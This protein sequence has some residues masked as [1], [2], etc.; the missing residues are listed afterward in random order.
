MKKTLLSLA[1]A[2]TLG[3]VSASA[4]AVGIFNEFTVAEGSVPGATANTF[5]ADKIN[6]GYAETLTVNGDGTFDTVGY[7]DWGSFFKNDGA[8]LVSPTQ[9]NGLN[10][11]AMYAVF[12]SSGNLTPTGF[13][14]LTGSF[15]LYID[16]NQNTSKT[17][18]GT[19]TGAVG[20]AGTADDYKIAF[21]TNLIHGKG[22][23]GTPGAFDL[24]FDDFTLTTG[25][26]NGATAGTQ[27]GDLYFIQPR[28]FHMLVETNGDFDRFPTVP[29]P[30]DYTNITGDI[31]A[32]FAVPEPGTIALLGIGLLG[33]GMGLRRKA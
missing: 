20:L 13:N 23:V 19:G 27:N 26:Q 4:S 29:G 7:A 11:Y 8:T 21:A 14:G 33:M 10:G 25:D 31:S 1:M 24:W 18:P 12:T 15:D 3:L 22:I 2:S 16:P 9:L 30:G 6:G 5:V 28:P 17:V 32:V